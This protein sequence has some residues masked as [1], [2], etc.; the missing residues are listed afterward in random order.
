MKRIKIV[1]LAAFIIITAISIWKLTHRKDFL[2]AGTL[3]ATEV[4][5]SPR[6]ASVIASFDVREGEAVK[7][8]QSLVRLA[9]EDIRLT[10]EQSEKDFERAQQL[11]MEG[12]ITQEAFDRI[13]F[14]YKETQLKQSWCDIRSPL[15]ATVLNTYYETGEQVSPGN[16]LL[17]LANLNE[18]WTIIYI[19]QTM[20]ASISL[21]MRVLGFLP[22]LKMRAYDGFVSHIAGEA[23]FTPKNVQTREERTR[24]LYGIKVQFSN[25]DGVLKPGM[26]IEVKLPEAK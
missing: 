22:E 10:A 14:K 1:L 20:L 6:V 4:D 24:L 18:L 16:K 15:N 3:E 2:Y 23:E 12:S 11:R 17:T 8:G 19:P 26:T 13:Y 21:N 25:P 5:I 7:R 9:G